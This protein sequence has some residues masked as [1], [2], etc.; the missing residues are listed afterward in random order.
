MKRLIWLLFLNLTFIF[1]SCDEEKN[2]SKMTI[3]NHYDKEAYQYLETFLHVSPKTIKSL[4]T[5]LRPTTKDIKS[6]FQDTAAQRKV[7]AYITEL[8]DKEKFVITLRK[9]HQILKVSTASIQDFLEN[10]P[11]ALAFPSDF[12][13]IVPLVDENLTFHRF[14]F[15]A[16]GN[17]VGAAY[18]G[19]TKINDRW[20]L[21]PKIWRVLD[22]F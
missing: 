7:E 12:I 14:K 5:S 1:S 8:Y 13:D 18:D 22:E 4:S 15:V 6:V 17:E 2:T 20:V 19:L 9:E 16:E 10:Q 3:P 21:F 11:T